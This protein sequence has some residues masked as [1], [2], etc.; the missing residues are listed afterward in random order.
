MRD[1]FEKP[2]WNGTLAEAIG[3]EDTELR[4][5]PEAFQK[6]IDDTDGVVLK[7]SSRCP[8][9]GDRHCRQE[10]VWRETNGDDWNRAQDGYRSVAHE[11]G[12][13]V[14]IIGIAAPEIAAPEI[15][16]PITYPVWY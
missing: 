16:G 14:H 9:C 4:F 11:A 10:L 6:Q 12:S 3:P 5:E 15:E 1:W 2:V 13:E 7:I 8:E